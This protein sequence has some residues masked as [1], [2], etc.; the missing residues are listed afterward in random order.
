MKSNI[1]KALIER[2]FYNVEIFYNGRKSY[3]SKISL[4]SNA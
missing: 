2:K 3:K 4:C 1:L